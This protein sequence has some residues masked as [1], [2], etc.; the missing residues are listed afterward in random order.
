MVAIL[1]CLVDSHRT[2]I[3]DILSPSQQGWGHPASRGTHRVKAARQVRQ[4]AVGV[5][6]AAILAASLIQVSNG[7]IAQ[8]PVVDLIA[9]QCS[10]L[11]RQVNL[12]AS[13]KGSHRSVLA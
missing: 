8:G 11:G 10:A 7:P 1:P 12:R 6:Q 3:T 4:V 5:Q 2:G 13:R 9:P